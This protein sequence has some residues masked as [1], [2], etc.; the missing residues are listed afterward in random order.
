M[1]EILLFHHIQGVTT[2]V[3]AFADSLREAGHTVHLPDLFERR[4]FGSIDEG[5]AFCREVGFDQVTQ[6]GVDAAGDLPERLVYAGFPLGVMPA[7][8]LLQTRRGALG[9]L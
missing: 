7:Q 3:A 1:T 6:R 5:A 8:R 9:G 4:T 2:G